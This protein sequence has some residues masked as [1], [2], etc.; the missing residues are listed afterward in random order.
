[1][2]KFDIKSLAAGVLIGSLGITTVF[3][4]TGIKSAVLSST[5]IVLNGE[6]LPLDKPVLSVTLDNA[7]DAGLYVPANTLLEKLGYTVWHDGGTDCLHLVSNVPGNPFSPNADG[8]SQ[9]A[10]GETASA[11]GYSQE[12]AKET[13]SA[14]NTVNGTMVMHVTNHPGQKNIAESGSFTAEDNQKLTLM[15]LSDI[16][17]GTVDLFL[18]D[19]NGKEQHIVIGAE[20]SVKEIALEKGTWQY[21]CSGIF[22]DGGDVQITGITQ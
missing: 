21:N 7:Q 1:M 13:P 22:R 8:L 3:A 15:I 4:A 14:E 9:G 17:G 20:N 5:R 6:V 11:D 16:Q 2:K 10:A 12:I 19:P 18:F